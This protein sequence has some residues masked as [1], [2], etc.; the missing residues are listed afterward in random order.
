MLI[1]RLLIII[2][3]FLSFGN[4][5]ADTI[6]YCVIKH[7]NGELVCNWF[8]NRIDTIHILRNEIRANDTI[9]FAYFRD[10]PC[11]K[12]KTILEI[13]WE[14]LV[15]YY[16]TSIGTSNPLKFLVKEIAY[17][18]IGSQVYNIYYREEDPHTKSN[19]ILLCCIKIE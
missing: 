10:T 2:I 19:R 12:C 16:K 4:V 8:Y 3:L 11:S 6:D 17:L 14:G 15:I 7:N 18:N 5:K 9:S 1:I 13:D